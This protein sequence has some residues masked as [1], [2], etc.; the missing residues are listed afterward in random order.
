MGS[1]LNNWTN[2]CPPVDLT[3]NKTCKDF[4]R[5]DEQERYYNEI[6]KQMV[7]KKGFH[8]FKV[9]VRLSIVQNIC[10]LYAK[11]IVKFH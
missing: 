4:L 3:V 5:Q 11:W 7:G 2:Y 9:G 8:K 10:K 6:R 1:V